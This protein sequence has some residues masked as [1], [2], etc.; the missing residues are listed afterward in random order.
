MVQLAGNYHIVLTWISDSTAVAVAKPDD[1]ATQ[2]GLSTVYLSTNANSASPTFARQ[3]DVRSNISSIATAGDAF[4]PSNMAVV[5]CDETQKQIWLPARQN[6]ARSGDFTKVIVPFSPRELKTSE[7]N[8][9]NVLGYDDFEND[10]WLST[11]GG[12]HWWRILKNCV[13]KDPY[14]KNGFLWGVAP[15]DPPDSIWAINQSDAMGTLVDRVLLRSQDGGVTWTIWRNHVRDLTINAAYI[16]TTTPW[17]LRT[18]TATGH[19]E[20]GPLEEAFFPVHSTG[21][22]KDWQ[23]LDE[24]E[25]C[26]F[27]V[28]DHHQLNVTTATCQGESNLYV[29]GTHGRR[30]LMSLRNVLFVRQSDRTLVADFVPLEAVRGVCLAT[31]HV[32]DRRIS[33]AGHHRTMVTFNKGGQWQMIPAPSAEATTCRRRDNCSLHLHLKVVDLRANVEPVLSAVHAPGIALATGA[34]GQNLQLNA[35]DNN[36]HLTQD[37]AVAWTK[38]LDGPHRCAFANRGSIICVVPASGTLAVRWSTDHGASWRPVVPIAM[39]TVFLVALPGVHSARVILV[40]SANGVPALSQVDFSGGV[41][42]NC[43]PSDYFHWTQSGRASGAAA[44]WLGSQVTYNRRLANAS[45]LEVWTDNKRPDDPTSQTPCACTRADY[46][47]DRDYLIRGN[48]ECVRVDLETD[49][50]GD[51][52]G[53]G[54]DDGGDV[55]DQARLATRTSASNAPVVLATMGSIVLIGCF[56]YAYLRRSRQHREAVYAY[57]RCSRQHRE[58]AYEDADHNDE[59]VDDGDDMISL[60]PL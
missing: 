45:C 50:P 59:D 22:Q 44:C 54:V 43:G 31:E 14:T 56:G 4:Q 46:D 55:R 35:I 23:V 57:L 25:G 15:C 34:T 36:V 3:L 2:F 48:D 52:S 11:D 19:G 20:R 49:A 28:V 8:H 38:I 16:T 9:Q 1:Q 5:L 29:S 6:A 32:A 13:H 40:G 10:L 27:A 33:A 21:V 26:L 42:R 30:F 12:H 37:G 53:S 60:A 51:G 18:A 17:A 24:S 7:A 58:A 47:C 41:T 39:S